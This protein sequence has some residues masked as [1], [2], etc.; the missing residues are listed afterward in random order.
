MKLN[1]VVSD[2]IDLGNGAYKTELTY[3][4]LEGALSFIHGK[5]NR[6]SFLGGLGNTIMD[7]VNEIVT[8]IQELTG[9]RKKK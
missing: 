3:T 1:L 5:N 7:D 4:G 8:N 9:K 6:D 2:P